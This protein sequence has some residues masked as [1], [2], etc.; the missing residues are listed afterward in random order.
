MQDD[1]KTIG[2]STPRVGALE[3]VMGLAAFSAD[4]EL[5]QPL[6]LRVLRSRYAHARLIAIDTSTAAELDGVIRV[7]TAQDIPGKNLLGIINQDQPLLAA[8]RVRSLA[9][10]VALVAAESNQSAEQAL[11]AIA[12]TYKELPARLQPRAGP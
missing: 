5:N 1:F 8:D 2:Q 12:V 4:M 7:F 6:V 11:A 3:R 9:D 10:P